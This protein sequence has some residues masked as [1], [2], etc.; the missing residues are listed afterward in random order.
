VNLQVDNPEGFTHRVD[1][2]QK[3][4]S[5]DEAALVA[6][7][8]TAA[9]AIAAIGIA[10]LK[11]GTAGAFTAPAPVSGAP[12]NG[13][14]GGN[15]G[16][17]LVITALDAEAYVVTFPANTLFPGSYHIATFGGAIG[18]NIEMVAF[19]GLLYVIAKT[20]ITLS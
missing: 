16:Q 19:G 20:G 2:L 15:D 12:A 8:Y 6:A 10:A 1:N 3:A 14:T 17:R 18:D 9:G 11:T 4:V 5:A 13:G 7:Q